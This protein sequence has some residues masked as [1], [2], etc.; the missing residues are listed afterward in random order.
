MACWIVAYLT[1]INVFLHIAI[2][3]NAISLVLFKLTLLCD[4]ECLSL[5]GALN[6][7]S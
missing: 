5:S 7:A 6:K 3:K 2:K 1:V 4:V